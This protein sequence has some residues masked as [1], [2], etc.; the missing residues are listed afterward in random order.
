MMNKILFLALMFLVSSFN[1]FAYT[2]EMQTRVS[3]TRIPTSSAYNPLIISAFGKTAM[4]GQYGVTVHV[5]G[6]GQGFYNYDAVFYPVEGTLIK[7]G[8]E[9]FLQ[10]D[11]ESELILL[12]K[13]GFFGIWAPVEGVEIQSDLVARGS[14]Y[15]AQVVIHID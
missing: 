8:K 13:K 7:Q 9:L 14:S 5:D 11:G 12:A 15:H 4:G 6:I 1:V 3:N 10:R 2:I